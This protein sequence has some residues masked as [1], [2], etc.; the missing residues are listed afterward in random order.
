MQMLLLM[1]QLWQ[2]IL[3]PLSL[4]HTYAEGYL[5]LNFAVL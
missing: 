3:N 1:H 2:I 5:S 4:Y